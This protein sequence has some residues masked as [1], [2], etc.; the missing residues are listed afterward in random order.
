MN[1]DMVTQ[2]AV[3]EGQARSGVWT[4]SSTNRPVGASSGQL[5]WHLQEV[6][7]RGNSTN[8]EIMLNFS[9]LIYINN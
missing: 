6:Y 4:F 7:E 9:E 2:L 8:A 5:T 3:V 1:P